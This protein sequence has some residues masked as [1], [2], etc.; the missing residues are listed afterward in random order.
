LLDCSDARDVISSEFTFWG[1]M[2]DRQENCEYPIAILP[3]VPL[4]F[5]KRSA[6]TYLVD[7]ECRWYTNFVMNLMTLC[8]MHIA[9]AS[10]YVLQ[11]ARPMTKQSKVKKRSDQNLQRS[12][13]PNDLQKESRRQTHHRR[14]RCGCRIPIRRQSSLGLTSRSSLSPEELIWWEH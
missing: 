3:H 9:H 4:E 2:H 6:L 8:N 5:R 13:S 1:W 11:F 12:L 7:G 10:R 14:S